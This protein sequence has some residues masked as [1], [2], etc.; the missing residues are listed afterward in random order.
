MPSNGIKVF[1][2]S[3]LWVTAP[4]GKLR[5]KAYEKNSRQ[6]NAQ[7]LEACRRSVIERSLFEHIPIRVSINHLIFLK[8]RI[9]NSFL[10]KNLIFTRRNGL[11]KHRSTVFF[12]YSMN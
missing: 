5:R 1:R 2:L 11:R 3:A 4:P 9:H 6:K 8:I 10:S 12:L 7:D